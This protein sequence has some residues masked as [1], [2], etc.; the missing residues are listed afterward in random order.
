MIVLGISAQHDAGAA[1]VIDGQ[2]VAAVNEERLNRTKLYWGW[3]EQSIEEV[4]RLSG[5]DRSDIGVVAI[6][7]QTHST[8]AAA[9]WEGLYPKDFKRQVLIGLSKMGVARFAG[10][11][12][13]GAGLYRTLN[14]KK[15]RAS[16][17]RELETVIRSLGIT[18]PI[19]HIDHHAAHLASGYYTSGWDECLNISLDGVGDGYCSRIAV[20]KDGR[21]NPIHSIP[22]YHTPGQYYGF[23]TGWAGF[24]PGKHEG[25]ITGL[26]AHGDP[27]RVLPYLRDRIDYSEAKFSFVN[28][29]MWASAE[30]EHLCGIFDGFSKEDV[31][32]AIQKHLEDI[33]S[34]Y[35]AQ[36]VS[37]TGLGKVVLSGGIF[38]NVKLNQRIRESA[39]VEDVY[40]HPNMGDGGL[41]LGSALAAVAQ[42]SKIALE[43]I[44]NVY[45]GT[46]ISPDEIESAIRA[47]G[48]QVY[49]SDSVEAEAARYLADGCVIARVSG[50]MEYGPRALGNRSILYQATDTTVNKWLNER[51]N[52]T[53]FMPFAP[54]ILRSRASE[55]YL[56]YEEAHRAA[57]FMTITYDAT[58]RCKLEAPSVVHVDGTA[59]P[60]VVDEMTN[61][62]F[63]EL[64]T[65]YEKLTGYPQVINTSFNMH[66]E[67]IVRTADEAVKAFEASRLDV[68]VLGDYILESEAVANSETTEAVGSR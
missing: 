27:S 42:R 3:P 12:Q 5:V 24:T 22:Y 23:V 17:T 66:E 20:C 19:D 36:A 65:E 16:K 38:A 30:Y 64:L 21:M 18:A 10:G 34:R 68:L 63:H 25:K 9:H 7:N 11:T 8:Y 61:P 14:G 6:A 58:E 44:P 37:R 56:G 62:G 50:R 53:E 47:T 59:R 28:K 2:V 51:L 41:A 33:V 4:L 67:P 46:D 43:W 35:V 39:C 60:Q 48:R 32:A 45:F 29:G 13:F 1:L 55:Y 40:I 26:A 49:R 54:A 31:S 15:L 52:R 57:E